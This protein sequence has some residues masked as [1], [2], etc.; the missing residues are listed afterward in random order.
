MPPSQA[1]AMIGH[2][3]PV[4]PHGGRAFT[5]MLAQQPQPQP[6]TI[7]YGLMP[8]AAQGQQAQ[9][10]HFHGHRQTGAMPQKVIDKMN[11]SRA[12]KRQAS[13]QK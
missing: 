13:A 7:D 4:A 10:Q 12:L 6:A 9:S 8:V 5:A 3:T 1:F 11:L 2:P